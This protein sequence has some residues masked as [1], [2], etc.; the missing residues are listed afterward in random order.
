MKERCGTVFG[1]QAKAQFD[2]EGCRLSIALP[3]GEIVFQKSLHF[4]T[5]CI[6]PL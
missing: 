6:L 2:S 3:T 4:K 1:E 5:I